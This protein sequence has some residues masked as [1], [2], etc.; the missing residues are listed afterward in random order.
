MNV[1]GIE[2]VVSHNGKDRSGHIVSVYLV[3][4]SIPDELCVGHGFC[5]MHDRD[6]CEL[7]DLAG[8]LAKAAA[9]RLLITPHNQI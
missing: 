3:V 8:A 7:P 9:R 2:S 5:V 4:K 6:A 1:E